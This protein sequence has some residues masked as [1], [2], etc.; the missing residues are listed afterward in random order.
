MN[1]HEQAFARDMQAQW[2]NASRRNGRVWDAASRRWY[3]EGFAPFQLPDF[4]RAECGRCGSNLF[5]F[6]G[7]TAICR[8]CSYGENAQ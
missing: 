2:P 7:G 3:K 5:I 4:I 1:E 8:Q 6:R